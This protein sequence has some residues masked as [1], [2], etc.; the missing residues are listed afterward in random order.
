M[1][2]LDKNDFNFYSES[3]EEDQESFE[4]LIK[5]ETSSL[6]SKASEKSG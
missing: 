4:G 5:T 1:I 3:S 2:F 6:S